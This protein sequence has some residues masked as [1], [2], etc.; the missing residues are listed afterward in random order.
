MEGIKEK[1]IHVL[2]AWQLAN[3]SNNANSHVCVLLFK[4]LLNIQ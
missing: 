3:N 1:Q 4:S 2:G